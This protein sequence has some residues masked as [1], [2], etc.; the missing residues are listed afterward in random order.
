MIPGETMTEE[1]QK[2]LLARERRELAWE[3]QKLRKL[4]LAAAKRKLSRQKQQH[5]KTVA[6]PRKTP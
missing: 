5:I 2:Q 1:E 4:R 6:F 3:E